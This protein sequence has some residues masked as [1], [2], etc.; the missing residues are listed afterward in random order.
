MKTKIV[1]FSALLFSLFVSP[2]QAHTE[3][4]SVDPASETAMLTYPVE[5]KLTFG[6]SVIADA[7]FASITSESGSV[8]ATLRVEA[9]DVYITIPSNLVA[10]E[11]TIAW[12]TAA[13]DGHPLDGE[14]KYFLAQARTEPAA[15]PT[16]EIVEEEVVAI[17]A[18]VETSSS[19]ISWLQWLSLGAS[20]GIA[21]TF[22]LKMR[23]K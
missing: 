6:E 19:N 20:I 3:L 5:I 2:I 8:A 13:S 21:I 7:T 16:E 10:P 18:P 22:F 12:K 15:S 1:I 14:I 23:K 9:A 11:I 4:I 17:N